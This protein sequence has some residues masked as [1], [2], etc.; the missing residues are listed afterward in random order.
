VVIA[1]I[2]SLPSMGRAGQLAATGEVQGGLYP[3]EPLAR[4]AIESE[5]RGWASIEYDRPLATALAFDGD[6]VVY[7]SNRRR[8]IVDAEA[9][10]AWRSSR[11]TVTAGL[12]RDRSGR[13]TDSVVDVLGAANT[14]FSLVHSERRL[15]QPTVRVAAFFDHVTVEASAL[16]GLRRQPLPESDQR[17]GF[18]VVTDDVVRRGRLGDQALTMRV[19][20]TGVDVDWS[21]HVFTGVNR[22][23]TFVPRFAS[24]ARLAGVD[25]VYTDVVQVG[26]DV[27]TTRADWRFLAEGFARRGGVDVAGRDLAY[28]VVAAAAEYQRLGAFDGAWNVI[29]RLDVM[30]DTRGDRADIPFASSLRAGFRV[31]QTRRL[32]LQLDA[33]YSFDWAFRGHGVLASLEKAIA[34]SPT[35][36]VGLRMTAFSAG[37]K[38]GVLDIWRDDLELYAYVRFGVSR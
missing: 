32:P 16:I 36:N 13:F 26:G 15:S 11:A 35:L 38:P 25:A 18:G 30:A 7:G 2:L 24:D 27:E 33:G 5:M 12:V 3:R 29:P 31:A 19:S 1:A 20:G 21:A 23:P 6:L 10:V 8:A 9:A 14:P 34:E 22:R 17:F 4:Q 37:R 28:G